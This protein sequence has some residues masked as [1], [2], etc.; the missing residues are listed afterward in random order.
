[1][2]LPLLCRGGLQ[3][4]FHLPNAFAPPPPLHRANRTQVI[5]KVAVYHVPAPSF[6]MAA[7][8]IVSAIVAQAGHHIGWWE[9]D[10]LERGKMQKFLLVVLGFLGCIFSNMKVLQNSNVE[11]FITFRSST[12]LILSFCDYI[13]LGR[14][15]PS[16]RSW[17]CLVVLL[18]GAVGYVMTDTAYQVDA[19]IW[20]ACW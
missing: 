12:P 1:L 20:L 14:A 19:Y 17:G 9:T 18:L 11:T 16:A 7:Q 5:N 13:W 3:L 15:L 8:M 10:A 4:P 2:L 6:L